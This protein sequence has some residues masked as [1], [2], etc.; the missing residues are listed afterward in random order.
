M[1]P[2]SAK[3]DDLS[4]QVNR[5]TISG[6][7]HMLGTATGFIVKQGAEF[8]LVTNWHVLSG[9]STYSNQPLDSNATLPDKLEVSMLTNDLTS[10]ATLTVP[11]VDE[12]GE[13]L[14]IAHP[15]G[16]A[17]DIAAIRL[18]ADEH[19]AARPID[20]ESLSVA[21]L[22]P[23]IAMTAVIIGFPYGESSYNKVLPIWKTGHIASEPEVAFN[24]KPAMLIDATTRSG[25]SGSPV[26]IRSSGPHRLRSADTT[27]LSSG[28]T[29]L[30]MGIY[31]GRLQGM[32]GDDT[33]LSSELGIVWKPEAI[34]EMLEAAS[35]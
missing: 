35:S 18:R 6:N 2:R 32:T 11:L 26:F 9:R 10:T 8:F 13:A 24:G 20:I 5:L 3:I 28:S 21:D 30:F 22:L 33:R 23:Q 19:V 7:G 12:N 34:F 14:W 25:M 15:S 16:R 4:A 29:T 31:S 1:Q 17:I 27:V